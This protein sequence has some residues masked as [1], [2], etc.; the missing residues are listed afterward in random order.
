MIAAVGLLFLSA[1]GL[2][3]WAALRISRD[4]FQVCCYL[5]SAWMEALGDGFAHFR[6]RSREYRALAVA[7][8]TRPRRQSGLCG[9]GRGPVFSFVERFRERVREAE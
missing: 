5:V 7:Q 2:L 8:G 1:L 9:T 3:A 6:A 4:G